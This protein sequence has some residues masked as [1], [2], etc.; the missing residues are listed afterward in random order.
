M[1]I[2]DSMIATCNERLREAFPGADLIHERTMK[3]AEESGEAVGAVLR[4]LNM[5]R[6]TGTLADV[7]EELADVVVC[8]ATLAEAMGIDL[9][10]AVIDK[11][12]KV[13]KR[14]WRDPR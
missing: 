10:R 14:G 1:N 3:L 4:Y 9:E 7:A 8:A 11:S 5:T 6:R 2:D 12:E 13:M